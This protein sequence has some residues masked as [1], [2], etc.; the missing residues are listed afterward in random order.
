MSW[1]DILQ[2]KQFT[3]TTGDGKVFTPL[4]KNGETEVDFNA[5][6]YD[7]INVSKSFIDRKKEQ[8]NK[9]PLVFWFQGED[10]IEQSNEFETS[11]KDNRLWTVEH[12]FYG[13][14]KGQ[15]LKMS[16]KDTDY[17]VTEI[18]IDFWESITDDYPSS[19]VSITDETQSK[20]DSID[21][22]ALSNLNE[23]A[24]PET[25]DIQKFIDKINKISGKFNAGVDDFNEYQNKVNKALKSADKL[26]TAPTSAFEDFQA[27]I[28]APAEFGTSVY[29]RINGYSDAFNVLKENIGNVFDKYNFE[30]Q[31][32]SLVSG[33]CI[34][35]VNPQENDFITRADIEAVND[36]LIAVFEDYQQVLDDNQVDIY[37]VDNTWSPNGTIQQELASLVHFTSIS[38]FE[39]SFNA[40]QE[41]QFI[42]DKD[43][44]IILLTHR[45][46]GL[47]EN[48]ENLDLF[49][50]INN[51]KNKERFIIQ[52]G[53][54]VKY[55]V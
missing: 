15:P 28:N 40:R 14:I 38:L 16:R 27:V 3:I 11:A 42:L 24:V 37:D 51:I 1:Q 20:K 5:S 18:N 23:N 21:E 17:N 4:W 31:A 46:L 44:N 36:V 34:A 39:L 6:K 35:A 49:R 10:N 53:R 29:D 8:S 33:M 13:T 52:K 47:D 25:G 48:D 9:Y 50:K 2:N 54:T 43:S 45:F 32:A 22:K 26:A 30:S 41:R 7:F 19:V 12:P 55:F